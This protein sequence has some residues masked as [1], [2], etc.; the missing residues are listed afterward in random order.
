MPAETVM[1]DVAWD[2]PTAAAVK[3]AGYDGVIGYI[4]HDPSKDLG[5]KQA[6]AYVHAGLKVALVFE[7]LANEAEHNAATGAGDRGYA[8]RR[9]RAMG[10]PT[11]CPIFYAVDE[12]VAPEKIDDYFDGVFAEPVYRAGPYGSAAV[13]AATLHRHAH[14]IGWQTVAW[15]GDTVD[16]DADLYQR[17]HK[18]RPKVHGVPITSYDEDVI[19]AELALWGGT[20]APPTGD[21]SPAKPKLHRIG[22]LHR[23]ALRL[24]ARWGRKD[25][26]PG[27]ELD[28]LDA[29]DAQIRRVRAL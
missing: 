3:A 10:Y 23:A 12:D 4:S 19:L 24:L 29:A 8:E 13:V 27:L 6:K 11:A 15:S 16:P 7:T 2:K 22:P 21:N 25:P 18:T 17:N 1:I 14:G 5:A 9:A 26:V 20:L 28:L